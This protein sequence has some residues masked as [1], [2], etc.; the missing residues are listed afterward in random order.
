MVRG[1][2]KGRVLVHRDSPLA[3][4]P[5]AAP[6][7]HA[8]GFVSVVR[9]TAQAIGVQLVGAK[10]GV[11]K[12]KKTKPD[13]S[14]LDE[15]TRDE[16]EA[17]LMNIT[18]V[19]DLL[20]VVQAKPALLRPYVYDNQRA[21]ARRVTALHE[22]IE[23]LD[24]KGDEFGP[25]DKKPDG[26]IGVNA[27]TGPVVVRRP[28]GKLLWYFLDGETAERGEKANIEFVQYL[29][30]DTLFWLSQ[31]IVGWTPAAR[32]VLYN[33]YS[34]PVS[35]KEEYAEAML[36]TMF[37][38][39]TDQLAALFFAGGR[40]AGIGFGT[41][42]AIN[43]APRSM[44]LTYPKD[45][46]PHPE[47]ME[48]I[49]KNARPVTAVD[50]FNIVYFQDGMMG[51][52]SD[53]DYK[54]WAW[55]K[56]YWWKYYGAEVQKVPGDLAWT[57]PKELPRDLFKRLLG[58]GQLQLEEGWREKTLELAK[59]LAQLFGGSSQALV[60]MSDVKT[61]PNA[62]YKVESKPY[63]LLWYT[64]DKQLIGGEVED[65]VYELSLVKVVP[66]VASASSSSAAAAASS[67]AGPAMSSSSAWSMPPD[68]GRPASPSGVMDLM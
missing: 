15:M 45:A 21:F 46:M 13:M 50:I 55:Q 10:G 25:L 11:R 22:T 5:L 9:S 7:A 31:H 18:D 47:I 56:L 63:P 34:H 1:E 66:A 16:I 12:K 68:T 35:A 51:S 49:L 14:G 61:N 57:V 65:F 52:L 41:A 38:K 53:E 39:H 59:P 24:K 29:G 48:E 33:V 54:P 26:Q 6:K 17:W 20:E 4:H 40:Q 62:I 67:S 64:S 23:A 32:R 8:S 27:I 19:D 28:M 30:D 37:Y 60:E 43:M 3:T 42:V 44:P 2:N 58:A 36:Q